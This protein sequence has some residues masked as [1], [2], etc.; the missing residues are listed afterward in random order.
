MLAWIRQRL[1]TDRSQLK[2]ELAETQK[3]N[4]QLY[5]MLADQLKASAEHESS[6]IACLD[7]DGIS[8][9]REFLE[10]AHAA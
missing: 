7:R 4:R 8:S 3:P 10:K 9:D 1:N 2:S 5:K 6:L